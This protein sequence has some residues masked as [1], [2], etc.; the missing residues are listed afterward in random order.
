MIQLIIASMYLYIR[1]KCVTLMRHLPDGRRKIRMDSDPHSC[2]HC[3]AQP[4]SLIY[5][6]AGSRQAEYIRGQL[7]C[8]FGLAAPSRHP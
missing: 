7:E 1:L 4:R 3:G 6:R 8:Q 2:I 5:V